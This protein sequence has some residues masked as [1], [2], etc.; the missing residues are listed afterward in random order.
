MASGVGSSSGTSIVTGSSTN[1]FPLSISADGRYLKQNNGTPFLICAQSTWSLAVNL[2]LADLTSFFSTISGQGFNTVMFN[3]I[4]H[5][6]TVVK[7]PKERGGN[8]PF[9]KRLD[10]ATYT[11]SPNGTS[12]ATGTHDQFASDDYGSPASESPDP[13]FPDTT[14]W[15][16]IET[17]LNA[18]VSNNMLVFIWPAYLGFH[19]GDEGWMTEMVRWDAVTGA[20]GFTGQPWADNSKSKMWNYGAWLAD[21]WKNYA[22]IIWVAGGDYGSNSQTLS[23]AERS[24]VTNFVAGMKSVSGQASTLWTAHWDRPCISTDTTIVGVSWSL[25]FAYADEAVAEVCR[26]GYAVTPI[27]PTILG[28]YNY[29][30]GLFG[31]SAPWRKYLWWGFLSSIAGGFFGNEPLWRID[32]DYASHMNTQ[33]QQDAARQFT[34]LKSKPW[35]RLRPSGLGSIGTLITAGGGTASPQSTDYVTAAATPEGD[36]LLAYVPPA[37]TGSVTVDMTKLSGTV[38]ARWFDPSNATYTSIGG[39]NN[40]G[41]HAFSTPGNNSAGDADWLLVLE[42][43]SGS[44]AGTS[45]ATAVGVALAATTGTS[46]GTGTATAVGKSTADAVGSSTGTSTVTAVSAVVA[47]AVG[48]VS[49]TSSVTAVGSSLAAGVGSSSG[50]ATATASSTSL[51]TGTGTSSGTCV[52]TAV[53]QSTAPATGTAAG[54]STVT[55]PSTVALSGVGA[56]A[57]TS[58][59]AALGSS[60]SEANGAITGTSTVTAEGIAFATGTGAAV[61]TCASTGIGAANADTV[62]SI[63]GTSVVTAAGALLV[64]GIGSSSGTSTATAVGQSLSAGDGTGVA[65]GSA[66]ATAVGASS[67]IAV[68]AAAG[69]STPSAVGA[70]IVV[71]SGQAS[72]FSSGNALGVALLGCAGASSGTASALGLGSSI[73]ASIGSAAGFGIALAVGTEDGG[74]PGS[75]AGTSLGTSTV[76]GIGARLIAATG[77]ASGIGR[78]FGVSVDDEPPFQVPTIRSARPLTMTP[79]VKLRRH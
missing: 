54:T 5:N 37:H 61:G 79:I 31:G 71:S 44:A 67:A 27:I 16:A 72:G 13:T 65:A 33:G 62:G 48:S 23:P 38:Q 6:Y 28:E 78:A 3:A 50:T 43:N 56:V 53:G 24:A 52:A 19:A 14:Y 77:I 8:L 21:R 59:A 35:H 15:Q 63:T 12:S 45:T 69:I 73:V 1:L 40:T 70:S 26:R 25:N 41:T 7:P 11:G 68:G 64:P 60:L 36:L 76:F 4:E 22:N 47:S 46:S 75:G 17:V 57:G 49:G 29:E 55:A 20:G 51:A 39:I 42:T 66:I 32:T 58:T 18:C 2:P 34:F 9:T 74:I 10:G 30:D